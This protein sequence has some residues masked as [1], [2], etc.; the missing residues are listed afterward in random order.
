MK[1]V[2]T[3][4][5]IIYA[6]VCFIILG[7]MAYSIYSM[8]KVLAYFAFASLAVPVAAVLAIAYSE[9]KKK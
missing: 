9:R 3:L 6:I 2:V 5:A 1:T 4:L 8:D 7:L